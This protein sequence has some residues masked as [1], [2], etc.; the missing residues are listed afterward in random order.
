MFSEKISK[1]H[2]EFICFA[3]KRNFEKILKTSI[4]K[5]LFSF[6]IDEID[7]EKYEKILEK[8]ID[9]YLSSEVEDVF[10]R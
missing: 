4:A 5:E 1:N 8:N 3:L 9:T 6:N 2:Q 10:L 7:A